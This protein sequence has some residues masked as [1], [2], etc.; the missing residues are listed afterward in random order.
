M[1][2]AILLGGVH[3]AGGL[4]VGSVDNAARQ[5]WSLTQEAF[6]GLLVCLGPDRDVAADRYLEMRRNLV[7]LFEWRGCPSPDEYADE[8]INRCARKIGEGE[9][10]RDVATYCI[11]IGRMLL[12]E[13][14]RD[15]RKGARSLD[16]APEPQTPPNQFEGDTERR[17]ECLRRCLGQLSVENR[18]LILT[19][20]QG[21]KSEK[22]KNRKS[23]TELFGLRGSAL[24]MRA[25]R[26]RE[27]L[28]QCAENCL[29]RR[30]G[31]QV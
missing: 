21:D 5:K 30:E 28:Q 22:I 14:N 18:D 16:E 20:Y 4:A 25:L 7:R 9:E 29:Q 12:R 1:G 19:Y 23:L 17:V 3:P 2:Y 31:N 15:R 24:R 8:T 11:G 10:I 6:D 27:A 26:L 13:M